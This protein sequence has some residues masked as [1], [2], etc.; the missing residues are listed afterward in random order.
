MS[1]KR[2]FVLV[3]VKIIFFGEYSV[4][5]GKFVIV[6]VIDLRMYVSV[7]F[8]DMGVIKIE[9]YDIRILGL[10]VF[11]IEDSIYFESDYGKVVE[12][13]GYVRQVIEFV[14]E[15]VDVNGK[16]IIVLIIFQIFVGVGFGSFVVVVVVIIGVVLRFF[17]FELSNEEVGKFGYKV[18]FFV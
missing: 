16:G 8:N 14:R 5:Y 17:G 12:V 1:V 10:I 4:V 2:V 7:E 9:V 13:F 3:L 11:F 15:E 6:V 18:E